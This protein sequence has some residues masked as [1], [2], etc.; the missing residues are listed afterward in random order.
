MRQI[1]AIHEAS[2]KT[3][4]QRHG[5]I[6]AQLTKISGVYNEMEF[7][8]RLMSA[9]NIATMYQED[10]DQREN[11]RK[12]HGVI[13]NKHHSKVTPKELTRKWSIGLRMAKDM[14]KVTTQKGI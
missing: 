9:V 5:K 11:E 3:E 10:I 12:A 8:N 7:C 13:M 1:R 14:L 2:A 4:I 6:E